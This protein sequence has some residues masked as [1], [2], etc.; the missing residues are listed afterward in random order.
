[1]DGLNIEWQAYAY[2]TTPERLQGGVIWT[3]WLAA[4]LVLVVGA[5]VVTAVW[6]F[7]PAAIAPADSRAKK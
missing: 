2:G 6:L 1:M 3:P 5:S 7:Y 4:L